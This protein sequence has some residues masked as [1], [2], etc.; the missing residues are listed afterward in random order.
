MS[1]Q[2]LFSLGVTGLI[3]QSKSLSIPQFESINSSVLNLR[4]GLTPYPYMTIGKATTL[5]IRTFVRK[6][7]SLLLNM[8]SRLIIA[9]L[10][11]GK[12]LLISWLESP[13]AVILEPK[14]INSRSVFPFLPHLFAMK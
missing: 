3:L 11:R 2:G 12:H 1:I 4:Y 13:S 5:I 9:F 10:S 6:V 8:L 14:K 7:M